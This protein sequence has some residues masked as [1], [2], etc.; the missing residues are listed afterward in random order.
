MVDETGA[1]NSTL[2]PKVNLQNT[3]AIKIG[4]AQ[5]KPPAT[6]PP[7]AKPLTLKAKPIAKNET[8]KIPLEKAT[9]GITITNDTP[10]TKT[11][12]I[13]PVSN[14]S[15]SVSVKSKTAMLGAA[16]SPEAKSQT[17]KIALDT[18]LPDSSPAPSVGNGGPKTIK[19]KRPGSTAAPAAVAQ[20]AAAVIAKDVKKDDLNKTSRIDLDS[21]EGVEPTA[22]PTRRK[23]IKVKRP[24]TSSAPSLNIARSEPQTQ[25]AGGS[26]I[27]VPPVP[28]LEEEEES[29]T[30]AG[31]AAILAFFVSCVL[32]YVLL[33]QA[34]G[35]NES[36]TK[37]SCFMPNAHLSWPG[38]ISDK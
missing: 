28:V 1:E 17:S 13:K 36:L 6:N 19:L 33:A 5:A 23:T 20:P 14:A 15:A 10:H 12:K 3:D 4:N 11:I 8:S 18:V 31:I 34:T 32:V 24:T 7:A 35:P 25:V 27:P 29:F 21:I 38:K 16:I 2:P 9:S 37:L 26:G 30:A 22:T